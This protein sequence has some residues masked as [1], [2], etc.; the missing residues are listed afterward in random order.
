MKP[1]KF[2]VLVGKIL[3]HEK[4]MKGK[5]MSVAEVSRVLKCIRLT[6]EENIATKCAVIKFLVKYV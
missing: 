1:L 3:K 5:E 2:N 6:A 4:G